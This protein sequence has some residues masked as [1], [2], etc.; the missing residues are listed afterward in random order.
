MIVARRMRDAVMEA[1]AILVVDEE[2][3]RAYVHKILSMRG[4]Q[5][6]GAHDGVE[7]MEQIIRMGSA[8]DLL[9]TDVRMPRMD[10]RELAQ[11]LAA[12][13]P[14][15]PVIYTSGYPFDLTRSESEARLGPARFYQSHSPVGNN[16]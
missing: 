16:R 10:G 11:R 7:A 12:A 4:Y 14:R 6:L 15:T 2:T 9:L 5:V 3:V 13:H 8:V 1:H